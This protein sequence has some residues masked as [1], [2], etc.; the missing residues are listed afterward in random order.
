MSRFDIDDDRRL[1]SALAD[2]VKAFTPPSGLKEAVR[3][4]LFT[5]EH[6]RLTPY[7]ARHWK[8][9]VPAAACA[10]V[11]LGV[12]LAWPGPPWVSIAYAEFE[13]VIERSGKVEWV[14]FR[15]TG[16]REIWQSFRPDR[17]YSQSPNGIW[18]RDESAN[19]EYDYDGR[20]NTLRI[21]FAS[22]GDGLHR[23]FA[24]F[25]R[26]KVGDFEKSGKKVAKRT[27][28]LGGREVTVYAIAGFPEPGELRYYV[29]PKTDRVVAAEKRG[30][31]W[32]SWFRERLDLDYP[33]EG[34][35]DVYALG[36]PRDAKIV[37]ETPPPEVLQLATRVEAARKMGMERF[38][39]AE[40][41]VFESFSEK[42][43]PNRGLDVQ[44]FYVSNG[45]VRGE[46]YAGVP[47]PKK[48]TREQAAEYLEELKKEAPTSSP[49]QLE[50]W[51][52]GRK[53][54]QILFADLRTGQI[55]SYELNDKGRL[56]TLEMQSVPWAEAMTWDSMVPLEG[57]TALLPEKTGPWGKL[58][59]IE[60]RDGHVAL[61][62][63]YFNPERDYLCEEKDKGWTASNHDITNVLEYAKSPA[64]QWF[65]KR[66]RDSMHNGRETKLL[67]TF[68]DDR[69]EIDPSLFDESRITPDAL[70]SWKDI[71]R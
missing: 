69:R 2:A 59:G 19:R 67:V 33:T 21:R 43:P 27:E 54:K 4:R 53:P 58:V 57:R 46:R 15:E 11:A 31:G 13:K 44:L 52:V 12:W 51:L 64:G 17:Y 63:L 34:P 9:F 68:L 65:V 5:P 71:T 16:G 14:H 42:I 37:D 1:E 47:C 26:A 56:E 7:K 8:W 39:K 6:P 10:L 62:R 22:P 41:E 60:I 55:V 35:K 61:Q 50:A 36:V 30:S 20:K 29:D 24:D 3:D 48:L 66:L 32:L 49:E 40:I 70:S 25:I 18:A 38:F 28:T 23:N 45:R